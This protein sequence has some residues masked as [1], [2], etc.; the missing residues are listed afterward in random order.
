MARSLRIQIPGGLYHITSRGLEK[1]DIVQGDQDRHK[2]KARLAAVARR[3]RWKVFAWVLMKNHYHLFLSTPEADLASGM[4]DLNSGYVNYF[5]RRHQRCGPLFQGRYKGILVEN[6]SHDWELS[7]YIHL[8]PVRAGFVQ[9]PEDYAWGSA[10]DMLGY[11][12]PP[13]W[14][15]WEEVL[16]RHG[17]TARTARKAYNLYLEEGLVHPPE[18]P[19]SK[20]QASVLLGSEIW[21]EKL[22]SQLEGSLPDHDVPSARKMRKTI[23]AES[24]ESTVSRVFGVQRSQLHASRLH[25]NMA[26]S[27]AIYLCRKYSSLPVRVLGQRF[28]EV[29]SASISRSISNLKEALGSDSDLGRRIRR[30]ER[31]L[32]RRKAKS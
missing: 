29:S 26:R 16:T 15:A 17:K 32:E 21:V 7:R 12:K 27:V 28:G 11:R 3:R 22:K 6:A 2:W 8:N 1:K 14:L 25:G 5:N 23:D 30:C 4:H 31:D 9:R 19:L 10:P 24:V 20:T 18:S 13:D